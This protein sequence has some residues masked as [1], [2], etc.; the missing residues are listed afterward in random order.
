LH[1]EPLHLFL[2]S[3]DCISATVHYL[4]VLLKFV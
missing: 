1:Y 3:P 4:Q 2:T